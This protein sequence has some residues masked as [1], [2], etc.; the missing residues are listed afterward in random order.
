MFE[1]TAMPFEA[2]STNKFSLTFVTLEFFFVNDVLIFFATIL[3]EFF[4]KLS[5]FLHLLDMA[6]DIFSVFVF[7]ATVS[8]SYLGWIRL[9]LFGV[10]SLAF[11]ELEF[12]TIE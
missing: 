6:P 3:L 12:V 4:M 11:V 2:F 1:P 8:A 10:K 5:A 9:S 7:F